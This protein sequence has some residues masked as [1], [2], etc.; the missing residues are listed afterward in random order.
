VIGDSLAFN[1]NQSEAVRGAAKL[2]ATIAF[3]GAFLAIGLDLIAMY[4]YSVADLTA[5]LRRT[6]RRLRGRPQQ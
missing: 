4:A 6:W 2:V 1:P 3:Y 5:R